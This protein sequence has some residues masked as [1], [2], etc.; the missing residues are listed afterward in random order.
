MN[1]YIEKT[2]CAICGGP[3]VCRPGEAW[4]SPVH[5]NPQVCQMY[6][7]NQRAELEE[8]RKKESDSKLVLGPTN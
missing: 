3:A 5:K 2:N 6:L 1:P 8:L 7:E 4:F